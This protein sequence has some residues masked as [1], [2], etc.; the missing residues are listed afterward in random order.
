MRRRAAVADQR[1][2]ASTTTI[3]TPREQDRRLGQR[4]QVLG[5]AVTEGMRVVSRARAERTA[6]NVTTAATTSPVDSIPRGHQAE[7]PGRQS[8]AEHQDHPKQ[9]CRDRG[10]RGSVWPARSADSEARSVDIGRGYA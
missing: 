9:C 4:R 6:K 10:E 7:A 2:T 8:D 5:A 3:I 1:R